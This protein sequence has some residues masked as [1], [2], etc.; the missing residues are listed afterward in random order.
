M[1]FNQLVAYSDI[2]NVFKIQRSGQPEN[3][4]AKLTRANRLNNIIVPNSKLE[5]AR[6]CNV[7]ELRSLGTDYQS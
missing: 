1:T 6:K 5:I 4:A 2:V 3:L 7:F